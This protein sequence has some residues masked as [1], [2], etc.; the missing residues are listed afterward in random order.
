MSEIET[1]ENIIS[2]YTN[3]PMTNYNSEICNLAKEK[4]QALQE[5]QKFEKER[6]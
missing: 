5:K 1:L 3:N 2:C 4:I 6:K